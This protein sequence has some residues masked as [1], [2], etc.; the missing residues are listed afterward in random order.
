MKR[1]EHIILLSRD[2]HFGLLFCW[3]LRQGI[4]LKINN[5]RIRKYIEYYW[6]TLLRRHFYEE[7]TLLFTIRED[8]FCQKAIGQHREIEQKI[9]QLAAGNPETSLFLLLAD[10]VDRHIR[11]EERIVFPHLERTLSAEQLSN[12]G[13][14]LQQLHTGTPADDFQDAFWIDPSN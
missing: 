12:I 13:T 8:E 10:L 6:E 5:A 4:R 11:Y 7:E 3:K 14:A 1:N 9:N 2:H